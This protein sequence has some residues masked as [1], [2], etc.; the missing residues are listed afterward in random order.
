MHPSMVESVNKWLQMVANGIQYSRKNKQIAAKYN[1][2]KGSQE[3]N[4]EW[5]KNCRKIYNRMIQLSHINFK[6][7]I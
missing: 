1:N 2:I 4:F 3:N 6:H 5:Q 7:L